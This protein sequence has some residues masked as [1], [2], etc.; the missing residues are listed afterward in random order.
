[1]NISG[2]RP[3]TGFYD[4][5]RTKEPEE[6]RVYK[7]NQVAIRMVDMP[8]LLSDTPLDGPEAA[9]GDDTTDDAEDKADGGV[10]GDEEAAEGGDDAGDGEPD[11]Y[12][13][14]IIVVAFY[15]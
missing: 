9:E 8:P 7:L 15:H 4:S 14:A 13:Q 10:G 3:G 11:A 2:I 1:M 6:K 12:F 5:V